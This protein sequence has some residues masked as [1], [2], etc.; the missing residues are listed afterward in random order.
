MTNF[1]PPTDPA[2]HALWVIRNWTRPP[3]GNLQTPEAVLHKVHE[4]ARAVFDAIHPHK[5]DQS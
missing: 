4:H 2:L 1:K 3:I 5:D